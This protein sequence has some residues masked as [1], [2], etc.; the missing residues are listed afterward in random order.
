MPLIPRSKRAKGTPRNVKTGTTY[1]AQGA[2]PSPKSDV[3]TGS[4]RPVV[5]PEFV[6]ELSSAYQRNVTYNS[7]MNDSSC[8]VSIRATKTPV[9]GAEFYVDP[10]EA[11][12]DL[13]SMVSDF[14]SDNLFESMDLS[15]LAVLEDIL[16]FCEDGYTVMQPVYENREWSPSN[17]GAN[18]KQYTML[19]NLAY[20]PSSTLIVDNTSYDDNGHL[21]QVTQN[22]IKGDGSVEQVQLKAENLVV[23]TLNRKGGDITGKSL[24]RTAY[25]HWYYKTHMYKVDAIQKERHALG[26][27]H[28]KLLPGYTPADKTAL[29]TLLRNLRANEES[30]AMETPNVE[31]DFLEVKGQLV[32]VLQSAEHHNAMILLNVMA[33]F[34]ALGLGESGGGRQSSATLAD[35][36]MKSLRY[37]AQMICDQ[38]NLHVIPGLVVWNFPTTN[39][40]KLCVRNIGESQDLQRLASA[41]ANLFAQSAITG[42][43]DTENY[44]RGIFDMPAKKP[45]AVAQPPTKEVVQVKSTSAQNN[46]DTAASGNGGTQKGD[47]TVARAD[48][49][50][51]NTNKAP[52]G[53]N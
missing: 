40:P 12:S 23:F 22:A 27:P 28:G 30:F 32:N 33:S 26:I 13:D 25:P 6:P 36:F 41:L 7:M 49:G 37:L 1:A 19:K 4:S 48:A 11:G 53:T 18:T 8:D 43:L 16:H 45:G 34:L 2:L 14:I 44:I 38:I 9:L 10:Y 46:I 35:M 52:I 51:G 5:L 42:D 50:G 31:I 20:R 21:V 17:T 47:V 39:F 29:A 15:W 3:E 24:L